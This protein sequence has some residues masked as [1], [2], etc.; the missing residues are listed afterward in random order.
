MVSL[1]RK[2]APFSLD[3]V[4]D[5]N[6]RHESISS[7]HRRRTSAPIESTRVER[8][9]RRPK[10]LGYSLLITVILHLTL[11]P[12]QVSSSLFRGQC[13]EQWCACG[14]DSKGRMEVKCSEGRMRDVPVMMINPSVEVIKIVPPA[15]QKNHLTIGGFFRKFKKL[16]ELHIV[17]KFP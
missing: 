13:P 14:L 8:R 12:C 9:M 5:N 3:M 6:V 7:Q 2:R 1:Y 17:S 10:V 15:D 11:W 16:E 4:D